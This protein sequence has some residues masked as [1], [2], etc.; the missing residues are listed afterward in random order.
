MGR[1]RKQKLGQDRLY[2][3]TGK[4]ED[5]DRAGCSVGA[6]CPDRPRPKI[7]SSLASGACWADLLAQ[8][9]AHGRLRG[10]VTVVPF[11]NPLGLG[12]VLHG[13]HTGRFD[14]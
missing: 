4:Q 6:E 14:L 8:V 12:Q 13:D 1:V 3:G 7:Q 10:R 11:A 2:Q 5:E 9:E